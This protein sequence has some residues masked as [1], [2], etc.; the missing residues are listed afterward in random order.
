MSRLAPQL[1]ALVAAPFLASCV[2]LLDYDDLQGG[3]T[4]NAGGAPAGG[5]GAAGGILNAPG[6]ASGEAGSP[7]P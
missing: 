2:F 7:S 5:G 1:L 4:P 6:G 3:P